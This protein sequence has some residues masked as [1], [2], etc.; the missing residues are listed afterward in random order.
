LATISAIQLLNKLGSFGFTTKTGQD[1][2]SLLEIAL[3]DEITRRLG[4]E[5]ETGSKNDGPEHL[6]R[7]WEYGR[8]RISLF[9][10][11]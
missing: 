3:L 5:E 2:G 1:V 7:D 4:K 11:P 9:W 8:S 6:N 10:V